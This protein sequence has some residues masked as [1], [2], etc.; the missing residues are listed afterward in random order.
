[1]QQEHGR[2]KAQV[3]ERAAVCRATRM[4]GMDRILGTTEFETPF[5]NG[6][7][8]R[9]NLDANNLVEHTRAMENDVNRWQQQSQTIA[10]RLGMES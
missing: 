3:D 2:L 10:S 7:V 6:G 8:L 4:R 5:V 9:P 1:M